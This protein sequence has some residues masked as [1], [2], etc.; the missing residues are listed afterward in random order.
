M[1]ENVVNY[2]SKTYDLQHSTR[3]STSFYFDEGY[4]RHDLFTGYHT[5]NRGAVYRVESV[6]WAGTS[7]LLNDKKVRKGDLV[8]LHQNNTVDVA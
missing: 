3:G 8:N 7:I 5:R 2:Q 6:D 4:N 1:A